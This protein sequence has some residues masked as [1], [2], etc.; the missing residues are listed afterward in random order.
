MIQLHPR[1]VKRLLKHFKQIKQSNEEIKPSKVTFHEP[2]PQ[3]I[4]DIKASKWDFQPQF[5]KI[6]IETHQKED[7]ELLKKKAK[8]TDKDLDQDEERLYNL[9]SDISGL[10]EEFEKQEDLAEDQNQKI[11]ELEQEIKSIESQKP[12]IVKHINQINVPKIEEPLMTKDKRVDQLQNTLVVMQD[13]LNQL[14]NF[15]VDEENEK[16]KENKSKLKEIDKSIKRL[17]MKLIRLQNKHSQNKLK[18]LMKKIDILKNK[19]N[20]LS[21]K[22]N[23]KERIDLKPV[24]LSKFTEMPTYIDT[25]H[26]KE[27]EELIPSSL[28]LPDITEEAPKLDIDLPGPVPKMSPDV[29]HFQ[30]IQKKK[31]FFEYVSNE[32]KKFLH[33]DY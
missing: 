28:D 15:K 1:K 23:S 33:I 20:E 31:G 22:I 24:D 32:V 26:I 12:I 13:K 19:Y 29:G 8:E 2:K 9:F 6:I 14:I 5:P 18:P 10:K 16:M 25:K 27:K 4:E 11:K 30:K 17:E 21:L 3:I 7:V